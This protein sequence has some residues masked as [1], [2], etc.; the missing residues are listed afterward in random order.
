M[1][2][3]AFRQVGSTF[4]SAHPH[5]FCLQVLTASLSETNTRLREDYQKHAR[6]LLEVEQQTKAIADIDIEASKAYKITQAQNTI[7]Y[8]TQQLQVRELWHIA[9]PPR[10][11]TFALRD[12][13][14]GM[15]GRRLPPGKHGAHG[16]FN[17]LQWTLDG[18]E[19]LVDHLGRTE[20]EAEEESVAEDFEGFH[21]PPTE[22]EEVI[23]NPTMRPMWLL[24]FFTSWG[25]KWGA[26]GPHADATATAQ[27]GSRSTPSKEASIESEDA[28]GRRSPI[29]RAG[30]SI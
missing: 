7:S 30:T 1:S 22:D 21:L 12:K 29:L 25:A 4:N 16:R 13:V 18:Q 5:V 8:E 27:G 11:T 24:R 19:R 17:R 23:K 10:H 14:F 6:A 26:F 15:G 3:L 20:S 28:K 2:W 9:S